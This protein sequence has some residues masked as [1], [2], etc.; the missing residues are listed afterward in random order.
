MMHKLIG[1]DADYIFK[2][3]QY[4]LTCIHIYMEHDTTVALLCQQARWLPADVD[5]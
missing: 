4:N 5:V 1:N 3:M 2:S